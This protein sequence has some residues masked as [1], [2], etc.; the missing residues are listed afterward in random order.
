[1]YFISA[2]FGNYIKT[3]NA[4]S[5]TGTWTLKPRPGL[6]KQIAKTLRYTKTGWRNKI[7]LRNAGIHAGMMRTNYNQVLSIA[8][9][10]PM[11]WEKIRLAI[12]PQRNVE[13][14]VSCPNLDSHEDTTTFDGF[15]KFPNYIK[16]KW[17]IVKIPPTSDEKLV[18]KLVELG[19]NIIHASNTL[20][21]DKGGLSGKVL[22]PYTMKLITYIKQTHPHVQIIAGGGVTCKQD[23]Q[24]YINAGADHVSLGS[25]NFTPWKLKGILND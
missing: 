6:L 14:N 11:D 1:M 7:G 15:D 20:Q 10:E 12:S 25:V 24:D 17:C 13:L 4:I 9:L 16:S 3:S 8:A 5:V 18:D 22:V 21:S 19:Y 23:A 2:P